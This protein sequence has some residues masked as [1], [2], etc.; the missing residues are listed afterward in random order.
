MSIT[1]AIKKLLNMKS[2]QVP[3]YMHL[4]EEKIKENEI[5]KAQQQKIQSQ[6]AQL[7]QIFAEKKEKEEKENEKDKESERNKKLHE[8]KKDLDAHKH[9]KIIRLGKFYKHLLNDSK[10]RNRLEIRDKNNEIVLDRFDDFGIM[11]GGRFCII[12]KQSGPMAVGRSLNQ[13]LFKPDAFENMVRDGKFQIPMDSNGNWM[14]DIE[15]KE[16]QEPIDAVF[17][18]ETGAVKRIIWSKVKTSV[19]RDVIARLVEEKNDL[20]GEV[21]SKEN[22]LIKLKHEMDDLKLS[23]LN[24]ETSRNISSS[25]YS[26]SAFIF[27]ETEKRLAEL[28]MQISKL[29]ELKVTYENLIDKKDE[30]IENVLKKLNLTGEPKL[31]RLRDELKEDLEYYKTVLPERVEIKNEI[32]PE[33]KS[34]PQPGDL[35]KK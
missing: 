11:S 7:S 32:P 8:Q 31:D 29:T 14:E 13:V 4:D 2:K 21:E 3:V 30:V 10:L 17:D 9:G 18:P 35:I 15:S 26:K 16:I 27:M 34:L 12:G 33:P 24:Y 23:L 20:A 28:Q 6:Q 22:T 25:N 1:S 19:V 5:I